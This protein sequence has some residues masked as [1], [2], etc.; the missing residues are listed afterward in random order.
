MCQ[1]SVLVKGP[2]KEELVMESV[3]RLEVRDGGVE[4]ST[5][6]EEPRFVSDVEVQTIDFLGGKVLLK[7]TAK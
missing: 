2:E 4:V 7:Q 6:F 3:T 1:M 5:F